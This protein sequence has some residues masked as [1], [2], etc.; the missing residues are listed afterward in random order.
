MSRKIEI[1]DVEW[2]SVIAVLLLKKYEEA[3]EQ[4]HEYLLKNPKKSSLFGH[5]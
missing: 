1:A 3:Y 5:F 2:K 4:L